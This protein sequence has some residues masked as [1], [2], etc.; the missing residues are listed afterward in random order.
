[1]L[2][3]SWGLENGQCAYM[4]EIK[5]LCGFSGVQQTRSTETSVSSFA[6]LTRLSEMCGTCLECETQHAAAADGDCN[7]FR[8]HLFT[9]ARQG[10][11]FDR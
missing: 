4:M 5:V 6:D 3:E 8:K 11:I 1:M 7:L 2:S 9:R 10:C